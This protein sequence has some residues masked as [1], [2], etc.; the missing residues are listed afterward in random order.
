MGAKTEMSAGKGA[1]VKNKEI[2]KQT[3]KEEYKAYPDAQSGI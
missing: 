1:K 2:C 3:A